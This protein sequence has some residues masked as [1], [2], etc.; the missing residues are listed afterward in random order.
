VSGQ[1]YITIRDPLGQL[2]LDH[3]TAK[4]L[5]FLFFPGS[6]QYQEIIREHYPGGMER[7]S[8]PS[9]WAARALRV[10]NKAADHWE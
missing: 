9:S 7:G 10:R 3:V 8:A 2:S 6:E 5:A 1:E 4:G